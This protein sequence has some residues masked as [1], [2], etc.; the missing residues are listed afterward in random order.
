MKPTMMMLA[1]AV[2]TGCTTKYTSMHGLTGVQA[3]MALAQDDARCLQQA[4]MAVGPKPTWLTYT[5]QTSL[6]IAIF[7]WDNGRKR[8][9]ASCMKG[10][11]WLKQ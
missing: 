4:T 8:L 9:Y 6:N 7:A 11:G 2:V 3:E 1:L 10:A 5:D